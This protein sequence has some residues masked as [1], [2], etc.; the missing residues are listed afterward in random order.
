MNK[1]SLTVLYGALLLSAANAGAQ[2]EHTN[3][4]VCAATFGTLRP[5]KFQ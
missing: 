2:S 3:T 4:K 1:Q 5:W